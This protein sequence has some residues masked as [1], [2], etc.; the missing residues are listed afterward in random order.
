VAVV[1]IPNESS[2]ELQTVPAGS[3]TPIVYIPLSQMPVVS[4]QEPIN[5][6]PTSM[7]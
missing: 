3:A 7:S 6:Q 1:D 4:Q 5:V 2:I